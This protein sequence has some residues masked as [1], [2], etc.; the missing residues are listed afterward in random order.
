MILKCFQLISLIGCTSLVFSSP[1]LA[2]F[3]S[4]RPTFF[5]DGQR[6]ME[7]EIL[8]LQQQQTTG[9]Q[10]QQQ[11]EHPSQ[12]L[13]IDDG[14]LRWQKYLFRDGGFSV[15]MPQGIQSNEIVTLETKAGL[16]DFEVFATHPQSLR[17][18]AAYSEDKDLSELGNEQEILE[19]IKNG[20]IT[21]TNFELKQ[22]KPT[23]FDSILGLSL[24]MQN[25]QETI[26]FQIY[27]VD[28]KVYVLAVGNKNGGYEEEITSFFDSF[29]L[30]K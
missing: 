27:L 3:R 23:T 2:Q 22:E 17:F 18:I 26:Y 15:W 29:R 14:Q 10:N 8:R 5:E 4:D 6:L 13:T 28:Q 25:E 21:K 11:L 7:Q 30:L 24:E 20:I 1:C 19:A 12:L 9:Q 16:V